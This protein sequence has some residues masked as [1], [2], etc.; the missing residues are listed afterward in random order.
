MNNAEKAHLDRVSS[1]GCIVCK[2]SDGLFGWSDAEIHH[3]RRN[4]ET[5]EHLGISQRASHFHTIP[6][7][8]SCHRTGGF[9][10]AYHAGPREFEKRN[11]TETELWLKVQELLK[12]AA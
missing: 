10:V 12:G 5:G 3:L 2:A 7:C 1:L 4:P 8:P 6:L 11:G 9:G